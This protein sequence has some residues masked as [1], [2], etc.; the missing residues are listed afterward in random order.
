MRDLL[1]RPPCPAGG[2]ADRPCGRNRIRR[3]LAGSSSASHGSGS[4]ARGRGELGA[5]CEYPGLSLIRVIA[6]GGWLAIRLAK[7]LTDR[8]LSILGAVAA[9]RRGGSRSAGPALHARVRADRQDK[10]PNIVRIYERGF[11]A[12]FAYLA[13][14]HCPAGD[15]KSAMGQP[16]DSRAG[17]RHARDRCR[18]GCR[19][20]PGN[21]PPRLEAQ[22]RPVQGRD[23]PCHRRLRHR[24]SADLHEL[25]LTLPA[26]RDARHALLCE[27][28]AAPRSGGGPPQRSVQPGC[29][30]L[31]HAHGPASLRRGEPDRDHPRTQPWQ[32][33]P[34]A[35]RVAAPI[36]PSWTGCWRRTPTS[37]S[38]APPRRSPDRVG[39]A[40]G[41]ADRGPANA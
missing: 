29:D 14:E 20:R 19:A 8:R 36:S 39:G 31:P 12:D 6:D 21:R 24:Q 34:A 33:S 17:D 32:H 16:P 26:R 18:A 1:G 23:H 22:Q 25:T 38:K 11:A 7:R 4:Y 3:A 28:R 9:I 5:G 30:P 2:R 10:H 15:L 41:Q 40:A 37:A 13:M 35:A 27:P